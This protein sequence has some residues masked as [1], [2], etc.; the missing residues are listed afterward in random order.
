MSTVE[1]YVSLDCCK[2]SSFKSVFGVRCL[3]AV[4]LLADICCVATSREEPSSQRRVSVS[5]F[6]QN[7][8]G[9][10]QKFPNGLP[11]YKLAA[12]YK[13]IFVA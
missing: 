12:E 8:S 11:V 13:V 5:E 9:L 4:K 7:L 10:M 1:K 2:V 3:Y 6:M